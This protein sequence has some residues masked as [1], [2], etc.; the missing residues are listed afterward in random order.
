MAPAVGAGPPVPP[1]VLSA[2]YFVSQLCYIAMNGW[3]YGVS[4]D[5]TVLLLCEAV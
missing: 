4:W 1:H 2:A 3:L 5:T